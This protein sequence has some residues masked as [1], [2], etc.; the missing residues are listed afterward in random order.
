LANLDP[1]LAQLEAAGL[2]VGHETEIT[3]FQ[4]ANF[5]GA[6]HALA[7]VTTAALGPD[8]QKQAKAAVRERMWSDAG[9]PRE[10]RNVTQFIAAEKPA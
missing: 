7:G 8:I 1:F 4:F 5:A 2:E 6:W 9:S 3:G 10:F